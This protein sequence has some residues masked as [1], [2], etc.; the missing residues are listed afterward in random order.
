MPSLMA[1]R[2][3]DRKASYRLNRRAG[4]SEISSLRVSQNTKQPHLQVRRELGGTEQGWWLTEDGHYSVFRAR[5][6]APSQVDQK[7]ARWKLGGR[8]ASSIQLLVRHG[9]HSKLFPSRTE[10]LARLQD[11]LRLEERDNEA[12]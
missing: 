5:A 12:E 2:S 3:P 1:R 7:S 11:I 10:A 6:A 8:E 9:V 4:L